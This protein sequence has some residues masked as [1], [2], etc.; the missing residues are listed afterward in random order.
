MF[1]VIRP[2]SG[3][4]RISFTNAARCLEELLKMGV[5]PET[6]RAKINE[7]LHQVGNWLLFQTK[8]KV[9]P[10]EI[11]ICMRQKKHCCKFRENLRYISFRVWNNLELPLKIFLESD[12]WNHNSTHKFS[13]ISTLCQESW[14]SKEFLHFMPEVVYL[15]CSGLRY[16]WQEGSCKQGISN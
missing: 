6:F 10:S 12:L 13:L 3:A 5:W 8:C 1:R 15:T 9:Q 4:N 7:Y 14:L 16:G 11:K 2:S